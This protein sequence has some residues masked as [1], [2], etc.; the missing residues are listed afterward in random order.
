[1]YDAACHNRFR[2]FL[3]CSILLA[4]VE[5]AVSAYDLLAEWFR[6]GVPP[7]A[8]ADLLLNN[9]L[10]LAGTYLNVRAATLVTHRLQRVVAYGRDRLSSHL[11]PWTLDLRLLNGFLTKSC[12][13]KP[14]V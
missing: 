14:V 1:M 7:L 2:L 8:R 3:L 9:V 10:H 5:T 6:H 12:A 13:K 11:L 4:A